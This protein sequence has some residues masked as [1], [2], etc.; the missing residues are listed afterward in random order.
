MVGGWKRFKNER[1]TVFIGQG[2][3]NTKDQLYIHKYSC[4]IRFE[5]L[6]YK[7]TE[8][9]SELVQVLSANFFFGLKA[10]TSR[11]EAKNAIF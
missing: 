8:K 10:R 9:P 1:F 4:I 2:H 6:P 5:I 7:I 11:H 3:E